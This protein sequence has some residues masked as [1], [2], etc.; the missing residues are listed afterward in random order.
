MVSASRSAQLRKFAALLN[1]RPE[2][3]L[4]WI[5]SDYVKSLG[6]PRDGLLME[7]ADGML[8]HDTPEQAAA[9]SVRV[10]A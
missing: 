2:D 6:D 1:V 3:F 8:V 10:H 9:V 5:L 7:W 4:A